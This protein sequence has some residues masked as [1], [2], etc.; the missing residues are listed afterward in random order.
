MD[1]IPRFAGY[2]GRGMAAR[3]AMRRG[4]PL[5]P[6][7]PCAYYVGARESRQRA[8][9]MDVLNLP[10]PAWMTEDL[11]LLEEQSRRFIADEFVPHLDRWHEKGMY[12]REVWTKAGQAGLLCAA[13][14]EACPN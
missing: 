11:V 4:E 8:G 6:V 7:T 1:W 2:D 14:P 3:C 5:A 9:A 12:A 10:R 13:M